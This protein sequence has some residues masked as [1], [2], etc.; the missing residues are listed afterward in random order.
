MLLLALLC[1]ATTTPIPLPGGEGGIGFDDLTFSPRLHRV[2]APA[3]RTGNLDLIDPATREITAIPG[4]STASGFG[5]GH[6]QGTTSAD[7]GRGLIFASDRSKRMLLVVDPAKREV[8]A[9]TALAAG[10]DYVRF[11]AATGEV[12]VTE[13]GAQQIEIFSVP[14][15]GAPVHAATVRVPGGPESL[16]IDATRGRAYTHLWK[17]ETVAI[18]LKTRAIV[19]RW[20][21]GCEGSR[22]IA[23]DEEHGLLFAG[24]DEGKATAIDLK[25]GGA[26]VSS[27][28][29]GKGV[30]V[31]AY[32]PRLKHLYVPG[33]E[34]ATLSVLAVSAEG[35]L[36]TVASVP[37]AKGAHCVAADDR[38]GA[39]IC[40]PHHGRL[41][42][43]Q[44]APSPPR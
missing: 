8:I 4:F 16:V 11:V 1:A 20:K 22:G 40:D 36:S 37:T 18:D 7:E 27:Q 21:N 29:T 39:W 15:H 3:G 41:L 43:Y 13:P 14:E 25:K 10:P 35:K 34:S 5:G 31:I 28:P 24:C 12:W 33:E 42:L 44:D 2:I 19:D 38:G 32:A 6:G 9:S 17:D 23:L 26:V 30:D